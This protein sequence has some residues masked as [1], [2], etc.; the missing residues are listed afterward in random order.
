[1]LTDEKETSSLIVEEKVAQA[2]KLQKKSKD[3][4]FSSFIYI[5]DFKFFPNAITSSIPSIK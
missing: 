5:S 1:M 3:V 4:P 2:K